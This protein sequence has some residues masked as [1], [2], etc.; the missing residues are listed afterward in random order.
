LVE[1]LFAGGVLARQ[2]M[3]P[4]LGSLRFMRVPVALLGDAVLMAVA[5]RSL[6]IAAKVSAW[7]EA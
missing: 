4:M 5:W 1:E 6:T 3:S 7:I 2:Q